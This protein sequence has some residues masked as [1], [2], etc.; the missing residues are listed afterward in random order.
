MKSLLIVSL[1]VAVL[2]LAG[3]A[4]AFAVYNHVDTKVDVTK[5][6]R[7]A[8][9]IFTVGPNET[10]NGEHGAGLDNVYVWWASKGALCHGSD[11]FSIPKGGFARIYKNEVKI[12]DHQNKHLRSV[13]ISA[14]TCN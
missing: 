3:N 1:C 9:P 11:N 12:Y 13:G 5:D 8:F 6:W 4:H 7:M 10:Y 14:S 2:L